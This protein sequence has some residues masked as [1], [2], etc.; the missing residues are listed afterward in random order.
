MSRKSSVGIEFAKKW[1][2]V[3]L[4]ESDRSRMVDRIVKEE[5]YKRVATVTRVTNVHSA[6]EKGEL[7][8]DGRWLV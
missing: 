3:I 1:T 2:A 4:A 7:T 5:G 8:R 6:F